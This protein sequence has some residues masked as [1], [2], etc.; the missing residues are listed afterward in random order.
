MALVPTRARMVDAMTDAGIAQQCMASAATH[1]QKDGFGIFTWSDGRLYEGYWA[2]G[3][4]HGLGRL[5]DANG[6]HR[7][8]E[9][10]RGERLG[11]KDKEE[12]QASNTSGAMPVVAS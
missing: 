9:W 1:D 8:A 2:N 4:Q 6:R 10:D 12:E 11:W 7:L 5:R 3:R